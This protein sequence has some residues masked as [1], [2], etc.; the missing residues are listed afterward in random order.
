MGTQF[1]QLT[2]M[3]VETDE[4]IAALS[5]M[6]YDIWNEYWP[7]RIGQGQTSYM[8]DMMLSVP[9]L[10]T[11]L[12]ED[13][14]RYWIMKASDGHVVGFIG[15][16]SEELTG[17]DKHDAHITRSAV[18]NEHWP[19][20]FFISKVY[21]YAGERG[22][23]YSTRAMEFFERICRDEGFPVMY[24]TVNR[25]NELAIRAYRGQGFET[26]EIVDNPIGNGYY[27]YDNVMAKEI[28]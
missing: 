6:A 1:E 2:F 21:L 4:E 5:E 22:K 3:P 14:Y 24:L 15:A 19:R 27:M 28:K 20:R 13:G 25:D 26:V 18:V 11:A 10:K 7:S 9:A 17:D 16:A 23:H 12:R 8:L